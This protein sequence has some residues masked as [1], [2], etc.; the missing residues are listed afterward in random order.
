[1]RK[2]KFL[3]LKLLATGHTD[4]TGGKLEPSR[5]GII[6]EVLS[7]GREFFF[8]VVSLRSTRFTFNTA[9]S[10]KCPKP[11]LPPLFFFLFICIHFS[12]ELNVLILRG[13]EV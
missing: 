6:S 3:K 4:S 12:Y 10:T 7:T 2:L 13:L 11:S 1:M 9:L 8:F 5:P